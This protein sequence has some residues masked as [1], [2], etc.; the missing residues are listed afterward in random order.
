MPKTRVHLLAHRR[1]ACSLA[2]QGDLSY[3][4]QSASHN[5]ITGDACD[6]RLVMSRNHSG[7]LPTLYIRAFLVAPCYP[8]RTFHPLICKLSTYFYR[9]TTAHFR[10]CLE[11][12]PRS[13]ARLIGYNFK[14]TLIKLFRT[15]AHPR[16]FFGGLRPRETHKQPFKIN[17]K[18][19]YIIQYFLLIKWWDLTGCLYFLNYHLF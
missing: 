7:F 4:V 12:I 15:L 3:F 11:C 10:V 6:Y 2:L 1:L 16:Y 14:N 8:Q 9:F 5:S 13:Q 19:L 17:I 18:F